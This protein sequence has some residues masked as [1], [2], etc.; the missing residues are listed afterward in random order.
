MAFDFL[1]DLFGRKN[2][3]GAVAP[4]QVMEMNE[5]YHKRTEMLNETLS[6]NSV[7]AETKREFQYL[8]ENASIQQLSDTMNKIKKGEGVFG[9]RKLSLNRQK[10]A[11]DMPGRRQLMNNA[12]SSSLV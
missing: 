1:H 9:V 8:Y 6:D 11:A 2:K 4:L 12:S 10:I 7:D 3:R 5:D